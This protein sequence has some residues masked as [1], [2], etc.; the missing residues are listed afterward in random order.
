MC[1]PTLHHLPCACGVLRP[2]LASPRVAGFSGEVVVTINAAGQ[3]DGSGHDREYAHC[4]CQA[5]E[6]HDIQY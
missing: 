6:H 2:G 5:N 4:T 3:W 1:N